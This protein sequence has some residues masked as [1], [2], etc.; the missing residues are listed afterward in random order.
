[1]NN[2][3]IIPTVYGLG[4]L[5]IGNVSQCKHLNT[6]S[7]FSVQTNNVRM[8]HKGQFYR[9]GVKGIILM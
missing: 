6:H 9:L 2:F 7:D 1:M 8:S 4:E 5:V 3:K